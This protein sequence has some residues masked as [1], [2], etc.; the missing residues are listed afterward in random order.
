MFG[1]FY[2]I[3]LSFWI[4]LIPDRTRKRTAKPLYKEELLAKTIV[5]TDNAR[6]MCQIAPLKTTGY[7]KQS[8]P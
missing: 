7:Q 1:A 8:G 4:R 5:I 6:K 2:S 3:F